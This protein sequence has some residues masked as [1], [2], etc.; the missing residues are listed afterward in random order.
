MVGLGSKFAKAVCAAR[1]AKVV[2][3]ATDPPAKRACQGE[4]MVMLPPPPP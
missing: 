2:A 3:R 1:K 4:E